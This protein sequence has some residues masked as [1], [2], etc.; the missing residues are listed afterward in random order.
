MDGG[1]T[2]RHAATLYLEPDLLSSAWPRFLPNRNTGTVVPIRA[3]DGRPAFSGA[4]LFAPG[5]LCDSIAMDGTTLS[6]SLSFGSQSDVVVATLTRNQ[7][8]TYAR[9]MAGCGSFGQTLADTRHPAPGLGNFGCDQVVL[10][11][12]DDDGQTKF[13]LRTRSRGRGMVLLSCTASGLPRRR[14]TVLAQLSH[15]GRD[16]LPSSLLA[17]DLNGDG[18]KEVVAAIPTTDWTQ[19]ILRVFNADGTPSLAGPRPR[20]LRGRTWRL[21]RT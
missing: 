21:P 18:R 1:L 3:A 16:G 11:D 7:A 19:L 14:P 12:L 8:K 2:R 15:H 20:F 17:A 13:R 10:A 9:T 5:V 4:R 6:T